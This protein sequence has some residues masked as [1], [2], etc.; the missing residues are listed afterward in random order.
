MAERRRP[1]A[2]RGAARSG[3]A[4]EQGRRGR[5]EGSAAPPSAGP[6]ANGA[7]K[8]SEGLV[9]GQVSHVG[10]RVVRRAAVM[11]SEGQWVSYRQVGEER[12]VEEMV[13][14]DSDGHIN[15]IN[16]IYQTTTM[17]PTSC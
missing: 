5:G 7:H 14:V 4:A 17:L 12:A 10:A 2:G 11:W 3:E 9:R 8:P 13:N 1:G 6:A 15:E 16:L